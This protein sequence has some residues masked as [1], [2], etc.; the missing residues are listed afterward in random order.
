VLRLLAFLFAN[1]LRNLNDSDEQTEL[2]EGWQEA[3]RTSLGIL[4]GGKQIG[5]RTA[6][7]TYPRHIIGID[8]VFPH[9]PERRSDNFHQD[10]H[11]ERQ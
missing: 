1:L 6:H 3:T 7:A 8:V 11:A 2:A 5:C 10:Q 4:Q 9:Q